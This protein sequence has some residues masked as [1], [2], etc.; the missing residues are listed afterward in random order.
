MAWFGAQN[1]P[2]T[3]PEMYQIN[4]AVK[5]GHGQLHPDVTVPRVVIFHDAIIDFFAVELA[6]RY[7]P[8][9]A[10]AWNAL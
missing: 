10:K 4:M 5:I 6:E 1:I 3:N 7:P 8:E 2:T 9:A